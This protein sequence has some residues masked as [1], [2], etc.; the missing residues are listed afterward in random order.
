MAA[1]FSGDRHSTSRLYGQPPLDTRPVERVEPPAV[2]LRS[3]P[4]FG[5][6]EFRNTVKILEMAPPDQTSW[7][8]NLAWTKKTSANAT[9]A[10]NTSTT[11]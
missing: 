4:L 11:L 8:S 5:L 3:G 1:A 10:P 2:Y 7:R 9:S 6:I